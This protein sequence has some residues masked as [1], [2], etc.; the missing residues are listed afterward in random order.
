MNIG[1]EELG[2]SGGDRIEKITT[3]DIIFSNADSSIY[4]VV[5]K[6]STSDH[7]RIPILDGGDLV[8]IITKSDI[9]NAFLREDDFSDSISTIMTREVITCDHDEP[10][11][12]VIRKFKISMRGGFPVVDGDNVIGMVSERDFLERVP[13]KKY[14]LDVSSV[15]TRNPFFIEYGISIY[16]C[17]KILVNSGYR[18]LPVVDPNDNKKLLGIVS[19]TDLLDFVHDNEY[20]MESLDEGLDKVIIKDLYTVGSS[21]DISMAC[22]IMSSKNVGGVLVSDKGQLNGIITERDILEIIE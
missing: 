5:D 2:I 4:S 22:M 20:D 3:K 9:L 14:G 21:D 7:R 18:R 13:I 1:L 16:D 10:V 17:L 8:G 11:E 12:Y 19:I 6:V 15:M